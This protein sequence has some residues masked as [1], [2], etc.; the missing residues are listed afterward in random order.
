MKTY[1]VEIRVAFEAELEQ[2]FSQDEI[3]EAEERFEAM[4]GQ[5]ETELMG[6]IPNC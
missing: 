2:E 1:D 4:F 6:S 5:L 3:S